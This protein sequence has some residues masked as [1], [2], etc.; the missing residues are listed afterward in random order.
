MKYLLFVPIFFLPLGT[1]AYNSAAYDPDYLPYNFEDATEWDDCEDELD[2]FDQDYQT[3]KDAYVSAL[4][5]GGGLQSGAT[6]EQNNALT[7]L[8]VNKYNYEDK[9]ESCIE[10]AEY[11]EKA[12]ERK[13]AAERYERE[14]QAKLEKAIEECDFDYFETFSDK[15]KMATYD[16]RM[17]CTEKA[18]ETVPAEV[19]PV[20]IPE[21]MQIEPVATTYVPPA[22]TIQTE[23]ATEDDIDKIEEVIGEEISTTTEATTTEEVIEVTQEELDRMVEEK[24]NE[25]LNEV[26]AEPTPKPSFLKRI[27]NFLFG[28]MF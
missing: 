26:Q 3:Y 14:Q 10:S 13:E 28:W 7:A 1:Y 5:G 15:E 22:P 12:K 27:T 18:K 24:L 20:D 8:E 23:S 9:F 4:T 21:P 19:V 6:A 25:K 2:A 17:A 11:A 16:E